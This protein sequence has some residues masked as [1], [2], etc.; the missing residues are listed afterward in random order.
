MR[1]LVNIEGIDLSSMATCRRSNVYA[2]VMI[3]YIQQV[4]ISSSVICRIHN[5]VYKRES[6]SVTKIHA[7]Q[8]ST[9]MLL[10][11]L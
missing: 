4:S 1:I 6:E 9:L 5:N 2:D 3:S 7:V 10:P 8:L 11:S